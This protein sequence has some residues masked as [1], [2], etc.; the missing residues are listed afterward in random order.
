MNKSTIA[1]PG[2]RPDLES[3]LTGESAAT[4][5]QV[6]LK[7]FEGPLDLLL[8]LI[9][10]DEIDIYDIP[11]A[12]ITEEYLS[13]IKAI[14]ELDV[15][16]A[17]EFLVMAATLIHIKSH[18]L[19]PKAPLAE[20]ETGEPAEDPRADLVRRLLE[21]QKY[22]TAAHMLWSRAEV[23]QAVYVRPQIENDLDNEVVATVFDLLDTFRRILERRREKLEMEIA[24]EEI[25]QAQKMQELLS[26]L[27]HKTTV[28]ARELFEAAQSKT[29]LVCIFLAI[30][31]LV[32]ELAATIVQEQTFGEILIRKRT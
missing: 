19:L 27:K 28:N 20:G 8:F 2:I 13:Y 6:K 30:L 4:E 31:E 26:L 12:R 9:K 14:Q 23:E 29:E 7:G 10:R 25:T 17:G 21:H 3:V 22:K 16:M 1:A 11:I 24:R 32:K 15:D 18:M 5:Y